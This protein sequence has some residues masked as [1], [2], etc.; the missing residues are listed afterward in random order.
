M[1]NQEEL[2][3]QASC[4][5]NYASP[6]QAMDIGKSIG[7]LDAFNGIE[8]IL[9]KECYADFIE[10]LNKSFT[11]DTIKRIIPIMYGSQII[12]EALYTT[13]N[14]EQTKTTNLTAWANFISFITVVYQ[15]HQSKK[16]NNDNNGNN[17]FQGLSKFFKEMSKKS[18]LSSTITTV[19]QL[20]IVEEML[21]I[22][23]TKKDTL[24]PFARIYFSISTKFNPN[25]TQEQFQADPVMKLLIEIY[26]ILDKIM[27]VNQEIKKHVKFNFLNIN[28]SNYPIMILLSS[29]YDMKELFDQNGNLKTDTCIKKMQ[30]LLVDCYNLKKNVQDYKNPDS[31]FNKKIKMENLKEEE[32]KIKK[33]FELTKQETDK[34]ILSLQQKIK[35]LQD[36]QEQKY[37]QY[38]KEIIE[39]KNQQNQLQ[40][41]QQYQQQT[42]QQEKLEKQYSVLL[43]NNHFTQPFNKNIHNREK[44]NNQ[45]D[46]KI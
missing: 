40:N 26:A 16:F 25:N 13:V 2:Q 30:T 17:I 15:T 12:Q 39:I 24:E 33:K 4:V 34:E 10:C 41:Q 19:Y 46:K 8:T 43:T 22:L 31:S 3:K 32:E 6:N 42:N 9:K 29:I 35:K 38:E 5:V 28:F 44:N 23:Q 37:L 20:Q 36:L 45:E 14:L 11:K 18:K 21:K 1:Q 27:P 7:L